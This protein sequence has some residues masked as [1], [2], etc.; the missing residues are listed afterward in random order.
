MAI[1]A[2]ATAIKNQKSR[3]PLAI[4]VRSLLEQLDAIAGETLR[5]PRQFTERV[6]DGPNLVSIEF[7]ARVGAITS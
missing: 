3:D 7:L 5:P 2:V 1:S 6:I 4:L